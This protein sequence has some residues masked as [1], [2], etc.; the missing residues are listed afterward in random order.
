MVYTIFDV[1]AVTGLASSVPWYRLYGRSF[2]TVWVY[3]YESS[4]LPTR[5]SPATERTAPNSPSL[6]VVMVH[7]ICSHSPISQN[8]PMRFHVSA[9]DR[10]TAISRG[11]E[12]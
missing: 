3:V 4:V 9:A 12:V 11:I 8:L 10:L 1:V 5:T 6:P 2:R 7:G